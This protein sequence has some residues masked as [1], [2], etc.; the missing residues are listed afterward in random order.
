MFSIMSGSTPKKPRHN[1]KHF[2]RGNFY[3]KKLN[4]ISAATK[5]ER[6][7]ISAA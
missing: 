6:T 3:L 4:A 5:G 7:L 1:A 2:L